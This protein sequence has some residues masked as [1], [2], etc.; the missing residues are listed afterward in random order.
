MIDEANRDL[1]E[2]IELKAREIESKL[3]AWRRDFHQ[4]PELAN[5]EFR[6]AGIV[7]RHLEALGMEVQSEI[8]HTG[9]IGILRG[10]KSGPVVALRADM[11]AVP[12]VEKTDLP[13][14]SKEKDSPEGKEV[15]VMHAC[16]HDAHTAI[17]M[18]AAEVLASMREQIVGSIKFI[19]QP[20][21]EGI[22]EGEEGG[23]KLMVE[24]GALE[25]PKPDAIFTLHVVPFAPGTLHVRPGPTMAASDYARITIT[26]KQTHAGLPWSGVSPILVGT[27]IING[28][29][30]ITSSQ[31]NTPA[32]PVIISICAFNSGHSRGII[33]EK[34]EILVSLR[35]FDETMRLD[36]HQRVRETVANI[37]RSARAEAEVSIVTPYPVLIND[38]DLT[39]KMLPTLKDV[40]GTQHVFHQDYVTAGEDV[41]YF[42]QRVPGMFF[43]LGTAPENT[44]PEKIMMNH[45]PYFI[46]NEAH[47]ITGLRTMCRLAIDFLAK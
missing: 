42:H 47:L 23:A 12:V 33:P 21:E 19:F 5:R 38:P 46:V 8:A 20:A 11:D 26:G 34:A 25:N 22:P 4:F 16:G 1:I 15:G 7:K 45:S 18:G 31:M 14:A 13:F 17:L 28:L 10:K 3:I 29:Q 39:E 30:Q 43:F 41:A 37:A 32:Y 27:Q 24:E 6:T 35:S 44:P 40:V 2:A 9:V 36:L